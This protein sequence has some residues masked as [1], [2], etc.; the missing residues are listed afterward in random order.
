MGTN[1]NETYNRSRDTG[2]AQSEKRFLL[3]VQERDKAF[4]LR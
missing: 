4:T 3:V 2:A 1:F